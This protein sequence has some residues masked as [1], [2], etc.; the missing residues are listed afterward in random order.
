MVNI[1]MREFLIKYFVNLTSI[2]T[3]VAGGVF[4][5]DFYQDK[6]Q[7]KRE[8]LLLE[9]KYAKLVGTEDPAVIT[10]KYTQLGSVY[11]DQ[12]DMKLKAK[13]SWK[14]L[15]TRKEERVKSISN[16]LIL[17]DKANPQNK[18]EV[19]T[20]QVKDDLT[21]KIRMVTRASETNILENGQVHKT[22][23]PIAGG[24]AYIDPKES[25]VYQE[26]GF[27][28]L[29]LNINM[30]VGGFVGPDGKAEAKPTLDITTIG[31]GKSKRDLDWKF[32]NLGVDYGNESKFGLH[33]QPA[34]YRLFKDTLT[35]TYM[36]P[37]VSFGETGVSYYMGLSVGL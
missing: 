11:K 1:N 7:E 2:I 8:R 18:I 23:I 35:N 12:L 16:A 31:Y 15:K 36:G 25:L 28:F 20:I 22:P 27:E 9:A 21:G 14:D 10:E 4:L 32:L 34:S 17:K 26:S 37:G 30:G 13:E 6:E 33:V 19:E 24:T 5:Y 3:L 29:P